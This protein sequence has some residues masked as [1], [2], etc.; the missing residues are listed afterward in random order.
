M[1]ELYYYEFFF[2]I[3]VPTRWHKYDLAIGIEIKILGKSFRIISVVSKIWKLE[4]KKTKKKKKK[5][6]VGRDDYYQ[7]VYWEIWEMKDKS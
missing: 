4:I 3:M 5:K 6:R 1:K 2:I 7:I